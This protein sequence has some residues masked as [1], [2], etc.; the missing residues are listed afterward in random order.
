MRAEFRTDVQPVSPDRVQNR[1][2]SITLRITTITLVIVMSSLP[3]S[4]DT[5]VRAQRNGKL[6]IPY[7][8]LPNTTVRGSEDERASRLDSRLKYLLGQYQG[9][10][11]GAGNILT[12]S[13]LVE[14]YRID[15]RQPNPYVSVTISLKRGTDT[16]K[17]KD[18]GARVYLRTGDMLYAEVPVRSLMALAEVE[19]VSSV[20]FSQTSAIPPAPPY[21]IMPPGDLTLRGGSTAQSSVRRA[22][23][24]TKYGEFQSFGLTGKGTVIG[25]VDTGIDWSHEDF[26]NPDG[27]TRIL[28]IWD[29]TDQ[30]YTASSG[31]VG[32]P[33]PP[34]QYGG[35]SPPGTVYTSDHINRGLKRDLVLGTM[36][37]N[38]HGT[39]CASTAAGNGKPGGVGILPREQGGVAP[40]AQLLIVKASDCGAISPNFILGTYWIAMEAARLKRP[41]VI[42]HS[43]GTHNSSHRGDGSA[44]K[45]LEQITRNVRNTT[46]LTAAAGNEAMFSLRASGRFGPRRDGQADLQS[47]PI[48]LVINRVEGRIYSLLSAYFDSRDDWALGIASLNSFV[49]PGSN[50]PFIFY[51][52]KKDGRFMTWVPGNQPVPDNFEIYLNK[53]LSQG[54]S[55]GNESGEVDQLLLPLPPGSYQLV[56]MGATSKVVSGEFDLYLPG[57]AD[58][59]F[60]V[61]ARKTRMIGSPGDSAGVIT[62]GAY[63]FRNEWIGIGNRLTR[64]NLNLGGISSYSNPGGLLPSGRYKPDIVGPASFTISALSSGAQMSNTSCQEQNMVKTGGDRV[65][66]EDGRHI[67]WSGTSASSPYVTGVIALMLQK[68]PNLD[69]EQVRRILIS[70]AERG[71]AMIGATPNPDWGYGRINPSAAL[72]ATPAGTARPPRQGQRE[73]RRRR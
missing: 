47:N 45:F 3:F 26:L 22:D 24:E 33:P 68:N 1:M 14:E 57:I 6:T 28:A 50:E 66:T 25:I 71:G 16:S 72:R 15:P 13:Q 69:T 70:T 8:D 53:I 61:G 35:D 44:G 20:E 65:V 59:A 37:F 10:T 62:V 64:F 56:G 40:D 7:P 23:R 30:T 5:S 51:I 36:D 27:T 31:R 9:L 21:S 60:T 63:D 67:A 18:L 41:V 58:G 55:P 73:L 12:E 54:I 49:K 48:N 29:Q 38:G 34:L 52:A 17:I 2:K 39:A 46:I 11:R 19:G 4:E 42:N 43:F 32:L